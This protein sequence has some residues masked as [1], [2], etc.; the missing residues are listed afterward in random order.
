MACSEVFSMFKVHSN[1]DHYSLSGLLIQT[2]PCSVC[3]Q[4]TCSHG[5]LFERGEQLDAN[6]AKFIASDVLEEEGVVL[7]VFVRQVEFDLS[8]QFLDEL[9]IWGLPAL[10]LQLSSTGACTTVCGK[11]TLIT[12]RRDLLKNLN[13]MF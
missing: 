4:K 8:D 7:Q 13:L 5:Y 9:R 2:I 1:S 3:S 10:L 12:V 6:K 11:R